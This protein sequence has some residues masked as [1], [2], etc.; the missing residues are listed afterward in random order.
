MK[1]STTVEKLFAE[2]YNGRDKQVANQLLAGDFI[3]H[4][5]SPGFENKQNLVDWID[6]IVGIFPDNAVELQEVFVDETG[7]KV[8]AIWQGKMTHTG[9]PFRGVSPAGAKVLINGISIYGFNDQ[10]QINQLWH[11]QDRLAMVEQIMGPIK[12]G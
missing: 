12:L 8:I 2:F 5:A 3:D 4:S 1:N 10:G 7:L 11:Q 6:W 9:Q